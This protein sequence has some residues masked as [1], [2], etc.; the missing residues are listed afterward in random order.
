MDNRIV[1]LSWSQCGGT[2]GR[3]SPGTPD[4]GGY[5]ATPDLA[6]RVLRLPTSSPD[7]TADEAI[8]AWV[9]EDTTANTGLGTQATVQER[10]YRS[11]GD[12][13]CGAERQSVRRERAAAPSFE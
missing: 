13:E 12:S 3:R 4:P 6:V 8:W 2:L 5:L 7:V 10:R 1:P 11:H 9:R